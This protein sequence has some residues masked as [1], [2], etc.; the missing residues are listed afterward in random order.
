MED[1]K[2][3]K[4]IASSPEPVTL[5]GTEE[6]IDQM[7][8]S[9]CRI[10][11]NGNGTG[12]F[13][14]IPY[15]S[16][17][18]PVL[19][20]NNHVINQDDILNNKDIS[21]YL[22]NDK[23]IKTIKLDNNRLIYTNEKLDVTIIEIKEN[24]DNLNNKYLEL[25]EETINYILLNKNDVPNYLN[26]IYSNRSIYLINYPEDKDVV[27]SYG[28]PPNFSETEILH[29]CTTKEGSSGSPILL[30][31]NQKLIGIHYGCSQHYEF[32]KGIL[33]IYSIIEFS[34]IKNNL[35]I[36]NKEGKIINKEEKNNFIIAEFNIK[37]D[38]EVIRIINS[39][40][41]ARKE[42]EY[43]FD[44]S[45]YENEKEIIENCEIFINNKLIPFSYF[46][47]FNKKGN[48]II[49]YNFKNNIKNVNCLFGGCSSLINIDL[50]YF[51]SDNI[52]NM[53]N[54]FSRCSSLTSLDLS[55]LNTNNVK[56]M[57]GMFRGCSSLTNIN[58]SNINTN[59]VIDMSF[60]FYGCTYLKD[61]N[62]SSFNT[63]NVTIMREMFRGCLYLTKLNISNFNTKN[64]RDM[65]NMFHGCHSM[66]SFDLS[67][68]DFAQVK[69]ME[70]LFEKCTSLESVDLSNFNKT[71]NIPAG[72]FS[73]CDKLTNIITKNEKLLSNFN[74]L[75]LKNKN[76]K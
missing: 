3:E 44:K 60:M 14:K 69:D 66:T 30:I 9:V 43:I 47:K 40:E 55:N 1:I 61:I 24:K 7:N 50:S 42:D 22:N 76:K 72:M 26:N 49:K 16:K 41:Q 34:K 48:Y 73:A 65:N 17:L 54:M 38:N 8:N 75:L 57:S 28:Q 56:D 62:L 21:L 29:K 51:N 12:F 31:N 11:N 63:E 27:V 33:L 67:N 15:K 53:S 64:V 36:I 23:K 59:K 2:K 35:L 39:Y 37:E 18:L 45:N 70:C 6:I 13:T 68:F 58:L 74:K 25:D 5:K 32:N 4:F 71:G 52:I 20:T 46:Y 10:Y 19:I